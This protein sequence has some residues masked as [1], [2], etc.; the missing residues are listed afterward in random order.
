MNQNLIFWPVLAQI[1]LTL[2]LYWLLAVRKS[3][4]VRSGNFNRQAAALDNKAW[5]IEVVKVSNNI[6]NQFESPILFYILC[7]VLYGING[8]NTVTV[9]L[10]W[11]FFLSRCVHAYVH[12]NSNYVPARFRAFLVSIAM[13][14]FMVI[15]VAWQLA[16]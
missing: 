4:V 16:F 15:S 10:A 9:T 6:D 13:L 2:V 5:P 8:T 11:I 7:I 3:K 14:L 12:V 1:I